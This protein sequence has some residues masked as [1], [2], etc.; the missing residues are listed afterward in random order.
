MAPIVDHQAAAITADQLTADAH[1]LTTVK[2]EEEHHQTDGQFE[3]GS[4]IITGGN[5]FHDVAIDD[6]RDEHDNDDAAAAVI[7]RISGQTTNNYTN[8][9]SSLFMDECDNYN[10]SDS[11]FTTEDAIATADLQSSALMS[12]FD[13]LEDIDLM[14]SPPSKQQLQELQQYTTTATD[15]DIAIISADEELARQLQA[16]ED[17]SARLQREAIIF[18]KAQ[19]AATRGIT[20]TPPRKLKK[21]WLD[22]LIGE[23]FPQ[24][25]QRNYARSDSQQNSGSS[26]LM[27][28]IAAAEARVTSAAID[29]SILVDR[30]NTTAASCNNR[31]VGGRSNTSNSSSS[32]GGINVDEGITQLSTSIS[33]WW[34]SNVV[35]PINNND[36]STTTTTTTSEDDDPP[37]FIDNGSEGYYH[38]DF[39]TTANNKIIHPLQRHGQGI[40]TYNS[41]HTFTGNFENNVFH[42]WGIYLWNDGD[43]QRGTW[44]NG[45]RHGPCVFHHAAS[46]VVEYGY[47]DQ[48]KVVGEGVRLNAER[49]V[50]WKLVDGKRLEGTIEMEEAERIVAE[51]FDCFPIPFAVKKRFV[52]ND[53]DDEEEV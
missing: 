25:I 30:T 37:R 31:G 4:S 13:A 43:K 32:S 26:G 51:R 6:T 2:N 39:L 22:D 10:N 44:Q 47:Y 41:G 23:P 16:E 49:T 35:N 7:H 1:H 38:G 21:S 34:S 12:S 33:K 36:S 42:G 9:G 20:T 15:S 19:K 52:V 53:D 14:N 24:E 11:F 48:G 40:M 50:A 45:L 29:S 46:D 28:A 8:N 18:R 17:E 3:F 27:A 5:N